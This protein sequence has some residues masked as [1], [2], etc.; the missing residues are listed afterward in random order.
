MGRV[1]GGQG[2]GSARIA[3]LQTELERRGATALRLQITDNIHTM[4][5]FGRRP[6]HLVVR[7]HHMFLH[8]P[9][10]VRDALARYIRDSDPEA[11]R[12][13]SRYI[14]RNQGLVRRPP[15]AQRRSRIALRPRG[16]HHDLR[17]LLDELLQ[18]HGRRLRR[19]RPIA[20]DLAI[21]WGP[22]PRTRLPRRSIKLGSYSADTCLIRIH[23]ALD[24]R[25][26]PRF[27]VSWI[28]FHE[29]LHHVHGVPGQ[30]GQRRIHSAAFR[31]DERRHPDFERALAWERANLERLLAWG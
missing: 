16:R 11:S 1:R 14:R 13:L 5:S 24:Q 6:D 18:A 30:G 2:E 12:A 26:V 7:M 4:L 27:F 17:L 15:P 9:P 23:P 10:S 29:L 22:A 8:A 31:A 25:S 19:R 20:E 21:T 3:L 28:V